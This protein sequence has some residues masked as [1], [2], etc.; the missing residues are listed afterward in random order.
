MRRTIENF[1]KKLNNASRNWENTIY[2]IDILEL[3]VR[4]IKFL[5][6]LITLLLISLPGSLVVWGEKNT[7][8]LTS[9]RLWIA[10]TPLRRASLSRAWL[11]VSFQ[12]S[13][14]RFTCTHID[15]YLLAIITVG[16]G[17]TWIWIYVYLLDTEKRTTQYIAAILGGAVFILGVFAFFLS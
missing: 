7:M 2:L 17:F 3:G 1:F 5:V 9:S 10:N 8:R 14:A 11:L 15:K 6:K 4:A 13:L 12:R 16:E